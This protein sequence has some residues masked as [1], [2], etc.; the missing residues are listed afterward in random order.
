MNAHHGLSASCLALAVAV[1]VSLSACSQPVG[2]DSDGS[3]SPKDDGGD[4]VVPLF[5]AGGEAAIS[6]GADG[7][8]SVYAT[9][10]DGDGDQD[11]LSAAASGITLHENAG[12]GSFTAET[13]TD[14]SG[15]SVHAADLNGDGNQDVLAA[16]GSGP[17]DIAWYEK[18]GEGAPWTSETVTDTAASPVVS[19]RAA[20]LSGDGTPD[21]VAAVEVSNSIE[22]YENEGGGVFTDAVRI[23][24]FRDGQPTA[25]HTA[26]V[27]GDGDIDV[28]AAS[29]SDIMVSWYENDGGG[30][31]SDRFLPLGATDASSVYAADLDGDGDTD[32]LSASAS[33]DT[34]RWYENKGE[35]SF[36]SYTIITDIAEEAQS[37]YAADLDGDGD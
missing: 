22:W 21:V 12:D 23:N 6:T 24:S 33:K 36:D 32:V 37:V 25:V 2:E 3:D 4:D 15:Q 26:D 31:F 1:V 34:L 5:E 11:V 17:T 14:N 8:A 20:D 28:H 7:A 9:D 29:R 13:I 27:D 35:G 18:G 10:L 16:L 30:S 19:L